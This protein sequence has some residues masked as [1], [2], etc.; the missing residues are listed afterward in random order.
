[1]CVGNSWDCQAVRALH[2]LAPAA[3]VDPAC[4]PREGFSPSLA[5]LK[6]KMGNILDQ[7]DDSEIAPLPANDVTALVASRARLV[8]DN[9]PPS[10]EQEATGDQLAPLRARLNARLGC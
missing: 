5:V 4:H 8:N 1:M 10:A 2:Q 9:E 7:A 3:M 6:M